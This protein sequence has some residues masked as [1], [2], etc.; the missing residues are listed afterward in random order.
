MDVRIGSCRTVYYST[1]G[2]RCY[3][4]APCFSIFLTFCVAKYHLQCL[5][6][7]ATGASSLKLAICDASSRSVPFEHPPRHGS[8]SLY[9][10]CTAYSNS[11]CSTHPLI[12]Q[13]RTGIVSRACISTFT[14]LVQSESLSSRSVASRTTENWSGGRGPHATCSTVARP[15]G[16]S[17]RVTLNSQALPCAAGA[18]HHGATDALLKER[19]VNSTGTL[20]CW[21]AIVGGLPPLGWA[22]MLSF[23][24]FLSSAPSLASAT[25]KPS[26]RSSHGYGRPK[27]PQ[28]RA[29]SAHEKEEGMM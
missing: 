21:R 18:E 15:V 4:G 9:S 11:C 14:R 16:V 6:R 2:E 26:P 24:S 28:R 8:D 17:V 22:H 25:E 12:S 20:V 3:G 13:S 29:R 1:A 5:S 10:S 27:L 7:S 23:L 19:F